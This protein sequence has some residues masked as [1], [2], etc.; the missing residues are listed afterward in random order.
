LFLR[1]FGV[2]LIEMDKVLSAATKEGKENV[3]KRRKE[4]KAT[5]ERER[6]K[7]RKEK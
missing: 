7:V 5:R 1:Y 6:E 3:D 4:G 2:E